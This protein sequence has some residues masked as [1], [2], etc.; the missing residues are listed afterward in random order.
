MNGFYINSDANTISI[1]KGNSAGI[2][3]TLIDPETREPYILQEEDKVLFTVKNQNGKTVIQKVLTNADYSDPEDSSLDLEISPDDTISLPTGGYRYDCLLLTSDGKA[4]TFISSFFLITE[5][6][7][8][9]T[10]IQDGDT[11][12]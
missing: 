10:D 12:E 1:V 3:I 8:L 6:L 2:D 4:I 11:G 5:A 7:G 9:Y